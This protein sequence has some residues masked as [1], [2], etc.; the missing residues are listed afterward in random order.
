HLPENRDSVQ[1][2]ATARTVDSRDGCIPDRELN[3]HIPRASI[4]IS[5]SDFEMFSESEGQMSLLRTF[6]PSSSAYM[7]KTTKA[8]SVGAQQHPRPLSL[9][10]EEESDCGSRP[11]TP[12][13]DSDLQA[14]PI[15]RQGLPN[16]QVPSSNVK[17]SFSHTPSPQPPN[18]SI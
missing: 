8:L 14:L 15:R 11:E 18:A 5:L 4:P 9:L 17:S 1:S 3:M 13:A 6:F 16:L 7:N 10:E 12:V 2:V